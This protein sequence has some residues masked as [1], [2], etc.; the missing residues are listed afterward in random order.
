[1]CHRVGPGHVVLGD[2]DARGL[3]LRTRQRLQLVGPR[4][5]AAAEVDRGEVLG[6]FLLRDPQRL[7][8][9]DR[10]LVGSGN[11][12]GYADLPAPP[13]VP[14]DRRAIG[15]VLLHARDHFH[16]LVGRV[17]RLH[18]AFQGMAVGAAHYLIDEFVLLFGRAGGAHG[19]LEG[20]EL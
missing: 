7:T 17:V 16:E 15:V 10:V 9:P 19:P 1:M 8:A 6:Q 4:C 12:V 14:A 3:A 2:D 13:F 18:D 5:F 11:L 20:T